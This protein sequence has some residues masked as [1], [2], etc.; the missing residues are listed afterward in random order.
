MGG[1]G[2]KDPEKESRLAEPRSRGQNGTPGCWA[3]IAPILQ[4]VGK[5]DG[6]RG[7]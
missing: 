2:E 7:A 3:C 1:R 4:K 6:A 5:P